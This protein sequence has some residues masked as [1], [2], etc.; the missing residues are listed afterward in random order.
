[1]ADLLH[2]AFSDFRDTML[3][4]IARLEFTLRDAMARERQVPQIS[5]GVPVGTPVCTEPWGCMAMP[6]PTAFDGHSDS[7]SSISEI[8][9]D[10]SA[11]F[12][13]VLQEF[14]KRLEAIEKKFDDV[15]TAVRMSCE[16]EDV[17]ELLTMEAP[18]SSRN[19]LVPSVRNTPALAAAIA[20]ANPPVFT[21]SLEESAT[22]KGQLSE[23]TDA[24]EEESE[25]DEQ[26][27]GDVE[28]EED[29]E[30]SPLKQVV[31]DGT[32]YLM[33]SD[34]VVYTE[35]DEGYE[36]IGMYDPTL[37][38]VIL[39]GQEEEEKEEE[40]EEQIEVEDFTYQGKTYQRDAANNV[41]E[42]GELIGVWLWTRKKIQRNA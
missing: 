27:E 12:G 6:G 22:Q 36:E 37:D 14:A 1:M 8:P 9:V 21:L 19:V 7:S 29:D 13:P 26:E 38:T 18:T 39:H 15:P 34:N 24:E 17:K 11:V 33:D 35:T 16:S 30:E 41:Y 2:N 4:A 25:E 3:T 42:D 5:R 32:Q 31:I 40:E 28:E 10:T 23:S 20:A